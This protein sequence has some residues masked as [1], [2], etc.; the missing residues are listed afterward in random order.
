MHILLVASIGFLKDTM[1]NISRYGRLEPVRKMLM[2]MN[3][4]KRE[5]VVVVMDVTGIIKYII[6]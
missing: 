2:Y 3:H 6:E 4:L 5:M 1:M